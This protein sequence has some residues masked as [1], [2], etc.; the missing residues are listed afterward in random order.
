MSSLHGKETD[1]PASKKKKR[2]SSSGP[3]VEIRHPY[4]Q[5]PPENQKEL[6]QILRNS[7]LL[8]RRFSPPVECARVQYSFGLYTEEFMDENDL[9]TLRRHIHYS[10]SKYWYALVTGSATYDP[11]RSKASVLS[12]SLRYLHTILAHTLTGRQE[13]TSVVNTHDACFL[14]ST[15]NGHVLK[16]TYFIALAIRHQTN[17]H[18]RGGHLHWSLRDSTGT[19]LR[20]PQHTKEGDPEDITDD[21]APRHE[22]PPS[23]P[24][25]PSRPVHA[26]ASYADISERL[27]R[28]KKQCF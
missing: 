10:P 19:T 18:Q 20:A 5:F 12:P 21:K 14:W 22:D 1:V 27:I 26:A 3:T 17:Q 9:D 13:S 28:F 6:F 16:L 4:L 24:P 15:V 8:S 7:P 11:S 23:Q 2:E 25:P